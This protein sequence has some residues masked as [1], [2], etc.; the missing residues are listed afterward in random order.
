MEFLNCCV[1]KCRQRKSVSHAGTK[2][3]TKGKS[4]APQTV[5]EFDNSMQAYSF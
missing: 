3:V 5:K 4:L 1:S 2:C